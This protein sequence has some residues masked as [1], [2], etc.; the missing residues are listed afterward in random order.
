MSDCTRLLEI[1]HV[2]AKIIGLSTPVLSEMIEHAIFSSCHYCW[3]WSLTPSVFHVFLSVIFSLHFAFHLSSWTFFKYLNMI[4]RCMTN[5]LHRI[6]KR[7][8]NWLQILLPFTDHHYLTIACCFA[9]VSLTWQAWTFYVAMPK[10]LNKFIIL[11]NQVVLF[12][13]QLRLAKIDL[14]VEQS[15]ANQVHRNQLGLSELPS[16][17]I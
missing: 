4:I 12:S 7:E 8:L 14:S 3:F 5:I 6:T 2:A 11:H 13:S 10:I 17:L 1:A 9:N 16:T 15:V